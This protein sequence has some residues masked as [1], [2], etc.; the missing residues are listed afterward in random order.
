M[1]GIGME[2]IGMEGK[3][4]PLWELSILNSLGKVVRSD[5]RKQSRGTL[6]LLPFTPFQSLRTW[7]GNRK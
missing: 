6:R 3:T 7:V 1:E 2:G 4:F 5:E